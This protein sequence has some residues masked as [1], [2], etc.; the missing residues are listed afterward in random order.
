MRDFTAQLVLCAIFGAAAA[1]VGKQAGAADAAAAPPA[2]ANPATVQE[3]PQVI[4]IGNAPLPG[5]GLPLNEIPAN[6][7][8]AVSADLERQQVTGVADYLNTNFSGVNVSESADNP[9][10]LDINYHGFTASPL[11]GTPEGLSVYVDGVRVNESFGDTVNWDLIPESAISTVSLIS[12]SNPVFGLNTLGGALSIQT[13]S[14]HDNPGTQLEA[15]G[16]SFGRRSFQA[17]TGGAFGPF[18]YFVTGN[19]FDETGWRDISP[20]RVRQGFGKVGWQT[21]VSDID[22]SYTYA[23]TSLFGNGATPLSMLDYRREQ[24]YTPD[25]THNLLHF[26]NLTG[27][28][29]LA[30][31]VLL[32]G[33]VYYRRLV[34]GS[35]NGSNNDN[36]LDDNYS[37]PAIDCGAPPAGR[38]ELAYCSNS[39]S[40][41]SALLQRT[42]GLGVQL[43]DSR[44]AFGW[45]NQG[46]LGADFEDS[47]DV[48]AQAIEYGM[49]AP[50]HTL[51]YT[52]DPL[53]DETAISLKGSNRILGVYLTDTLSPNRLLHFTASARYNSN[54]ETIDGYSVDTDVGDVG[55]GFAQAA[56]LAG[57]HS[58]SRLNPALGFT[59]TPSDALTLYA[60]YNEAS[61]A[62]TVVELGCANPA[63]PCGLPNDFASDPGLRQVVARTFE[64]GLRGNRPDGFLS[65]SADLFR[66]LN[67]DDIQFIA[68]TTNS[69]YFD[70]VGST[71]RQGMDLTLGGRQGR[72]KWHLAYSYVDATFQSNFVVSANSNSTA[73]ANGNI[74]VRP[75][76]RIPLIPRHTGRLVLDYELAERWDIGGNLIVASGSFLHGDENNANQGGGTNGQGAYILPTATGWIPGYAVVNLQATGHLS[77]SLDVF[78][79]LTNLLNRQYATAGFLTSNTFNPDGTFRFDPAQ[80]TNEN[81]ES[82]A[83]PRAIWGGVRLHFNP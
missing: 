52:A 1:I 18:D 76:D 4:V 24:S 37:G 6:V 75:G 22:L 44:D 80:W 41:V 73:D 64:V 29:L 58:F 19:L 74:L 51:I 12:G 48:F 66:T 78:A 43:T 13:K 38:A 55:A 40:E 5:F 83:A 21:E 32:S 79:R 14:G 59:L 2:R 49:F 16:G 39:A 34:T 7:Q 57:N 20:T 8:S 67:Q 61:R 45:K 62:P 71:R 35:S 17:E 33:N 31:A 65:W 72:F 28:Q 60:N 27:T 25:F 11:L 50:D 68:T 23:D 69:G 3:L 47:T 30:A 42:L 63:Q 70:N 77:S 36:F 54:R 9:F 82:P 81:A 10:Q 15:S 56:P 46:I 26:V 53:N